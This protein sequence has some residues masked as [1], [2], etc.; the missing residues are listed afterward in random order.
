MEHNLILLIIDLRLLCALLSHHHVRHLDFLIV[1]HA[2][3]GR[4]LRAELPD[5]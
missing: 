5:I 2:Q 4:C 1:Y 3:C